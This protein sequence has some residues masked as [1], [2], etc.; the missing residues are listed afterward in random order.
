M[1]FSRFEV[2]LDNKNSKNN[3]PGWSL[4]AHG[5]YDSHIPN[6]FSFVYLSTLNL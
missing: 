6:C 2:S 4:N 1:N 3:P 5:V